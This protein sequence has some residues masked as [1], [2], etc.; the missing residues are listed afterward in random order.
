MR[1]NQE[2]S[3]GM[4]ASVAR[5][6]KRGIL[7][8]LQVAA[9]G[10]GGWS[11]ASA[12]DAEPVAMDAV[13]V[14][15]SR[16]PRDSNLE[17]TS[18][19]QTVEAEALTTGGNFN[20]ID[21]LDDVP[22]LLFSTTSETSNQD[23]AGGAA[24]QN[25]LNLR[26]LG[27]E[28]TL[29]LVNGRRHVSGVEG[30][31]AV[32]IGSIPPALIERVEVLTGGASAIYGA[33]AVT[34]VVNFVLKDDFEGSVVNVRG[35]VT[36][37]GGGEALTFSGL[38]GRNLFDGRGNITVGVDY[39]DD[40]GLRMGERDFARDNRIASAGPGPNPARIFQ[41]GE[42]QAANTPNFAE[43]FGFGDAIPSAE[44]FI[45]AFTASNGMAPNLT[46]AELALL[47]RAAAAPPRAILPFR[48]FSIS[49]TRGV[50]AAG[51]FSQPDIDLNGNGIPDCSE[52]FNGVVF[53]NCWVPGDDGLLRPFQDGLISDGVNGFGGDGAELYFSGD[54]LVPKETRS[55]LNVNGRFDIRP[56][57]RFFAEAKM[58]LQDVDSGGPY[59]TFWDLLTGA[60]DNPFLPT[61]LQALAQEVGGLFIT[62]DNLDL[63]P[64]I[65]TNERRTYRMVT[66]LE[67]EWLSYKYEVAANY[68]RFERKL[69]DRNAVLTDRWLAA[70]DAVSDPTTGEPICRSD[71]DATPPPASLSGF[72]FWDT[73]FFTFT[74]GDGRCRPANIWSGIGG[75]SQEAIDFITTTLTDR[76]VIT[77]S[78]LSATLVGDSSDF[79]SLPA[80]PIGFAIGMEWRKEE[81]RAE[82]DPINL[83][84][85]PEGAPF[86]AGTLV[87]D[88]SDN[89]NLG[90][91][92]SIKVNNARGSYIA[93]DVFAEIRVPVLSDMPFAQELSL[94]S[95]IRFADYTTVGNTNTWKVAAAWAPVADARFRGSVSQAVRAPNIFE[96]FSPDQAATFRPDDPCSVEQLSALQ[97]ADPNTAMIRAANCQADGLPEDF[98]DPLT[99]R[100]SGVIGGNANLQE[101]TADTQTIGIVLQPRF[102]PR[103]TLSI[104]HWT[105]EIED[106]ID[107]VGAQDIVDNCYDSPTFPNDFCGLF[108][109]NRDGE[110]PQFLGLNFLR[111]SQINF[112]AIEASGVDFAARYGFFVG[113]HQF[114]LDT[115]ATRQN[116]LDFFFDPSDASAVDPELGETGRPEWSGSGSLSWRY[117]NLA[118]QWNTQYLGSQLLRGAE[119]ETF[120]TIFGPSVKAAPIILHGISARYAATGQLSVYGGIN[121][122][123]DKQPLATEFARPTGPRGRFF[124]AGAE[125]R[126]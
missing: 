70:I 90:F 29:V 71:I 26:G 49:S 31:Q 14:V 33:D 78:V 115:I 106:A 98:R 13:E 22:A 73:G 89:R 38:F 91:D 105:I 10:G 53:S 83:G 17:A 12:Q 65:T 9:I 103:L 35:G 36:G 24:G 1:A 81:S 21:V 52:S 74:P 72:P 124:Y 7:A 88:V 87:E 108:T 125:F 25:T 3:A 2:A 27:G 4:L 104:D 5:T 23:T 58:V 111:Q 122:L 48:T 32:E 60:P 126:F 92:G 50:I 67:G 113:D 96:L 28:R 20:L 123:T 95:A 114:V 44:A 37:E 57:M 16:I 59:N 42:I 41:I 45:E 47:Q 109:R 97:A 30:T 34:G 100:F 8:L 69:T 84:I 82:L 85:I 77:Q 75:I 93:R 101:E 61:E 18:P 107:A 116:K 99:G 117:S 110:S 63:G 80:G 64:N 62:R 46:P 79:F 118:V 56:D 6:G 86:E 120:E 54:F 121:N 112:G 119:V 68:G 66:G 39:Y 15:G 43:F 40:R 51:D 55:S 11:V 94:E 76:D 102:I 19:V